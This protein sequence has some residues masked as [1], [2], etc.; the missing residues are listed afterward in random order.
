MCIEHLD[1]DADRSGERIAYKV[2][3]QWYYPDQ[4]LAPFRH[5][6]ISTVKGEWHRDTKCAWLPT[7]RGEKY[8]TGF[9]VFETLEDAQQCAQLLRDGHRS[10]VSDPDG[11]A[12]EYVVVRVMVREITAIGTQRLYTF[13]RPR[14]NE[15]CQFR[16]LAAREILFDAV[17]E[18][19]QVKTKTPT[20]TEEPATDAVVI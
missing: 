18:E 6:P 15:P 3:M 16:V 7:S 13:V 9:H 10:V 19:A 2:M 11:I 20:P 8:L 4:Y 12:N 17:V 1:H 5:E 14:P